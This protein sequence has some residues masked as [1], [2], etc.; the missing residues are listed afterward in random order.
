MSEI[1]RQF[2]LVIEPRESRPL[3]SGKAGSKPAVGSN[4][5]SV[6]NTHLRSERRYLN[7]E[8]TE[9]ERTDWITLLTHQCENAA[10]RKRHLLSGSLATS[11]HT[12]GEPH[13]FP[14]SRERLKT[15]DR[16]AR[17]ARRWNSS[18]NTGSYFDLCGV[19][20]TRGEV[21]TLKASPKRASALAVGN[22]CSHD[23]RTHQ[24]PVQFQ[25]QV[26]PL[27]Q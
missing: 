18:T 23:S 17:K 8:C 9:A 14:V 3:R 22:Q 26:N 13:N 7:T 4:F 27:K 10:F 16:R 20:V 11:G 25:P 21:E 6:K 24:Q 12:G 5:Q 15:Q 1:C 19:D 2:N